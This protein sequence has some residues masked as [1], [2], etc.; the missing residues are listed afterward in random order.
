MTSNTSSLVLSVEVSS[1]H[2]NSPYMQLYIQSSVADKGVDMEHFAAERTE[3]YLAALFSDL[4]AAFIV[5]A[6]EATVFV[7]SHGAGV[8][9][10][11]TKRAALALAH[12]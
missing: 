9:I 4:I 3:T 5:I 11:D 12:S 8:Q 6:T 10:T 7:A 2:S 1:F